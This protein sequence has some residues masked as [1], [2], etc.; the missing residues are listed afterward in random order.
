VAAGQTQTVS[1]GKVCKDM[2]EQ[3]A[4]KLNL[5]KNSKK[6]VQNENKMENEK[7]QSVNAHRTQDEEMCARLRTEHG[8]LS[9]ICWVNVAYEC[10]GMLPWQLPS[11]APEGNRLLKCNQ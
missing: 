2:A 6:K 9:K 7:R 4:E 1:R 5:K 3:M 11:E 10:F 8:C